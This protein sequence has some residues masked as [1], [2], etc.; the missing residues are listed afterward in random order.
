MNCLK[1][2][3]KGVITDV[4]PQTFKYYDF[5]GAKVISGE[6]YYIA[7]AVGLGA[8]KPKTKS[9]AKAEK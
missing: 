1:V 5:S 3:L 2:E 9:K 7:K 4:T 8:I 6:K